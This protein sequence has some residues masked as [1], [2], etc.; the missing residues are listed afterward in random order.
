M[1]SMVRFVRRFSSRPFSTLVAAPVRARWLA[2][3][4]RN[5]NNRPT[6]SCCFKWW[7]RIEA[8]SRQ[9]VSFSSFT[10]NDHHFYVS[11]LAFRC[12]K[13]RWTSRPSPPVSGASSASRPAPAWGSGT[14]PPI[15]VVFQ[16]ALL[17]SPLEMGTGSGRARIC[18]R[19]G[20]VTKWGKKE[21]KLTTN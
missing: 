13:P 4:M 16:I 18:N 6:I 5:F 14:R 17:S 21:K 20:R 8:I 11:K 10:Y 2:K 7:R 3:A 9:S 12:K 15:A 19:F 1:A